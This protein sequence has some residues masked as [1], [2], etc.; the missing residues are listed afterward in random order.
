MG[1]GIVSK[2]PAKFSKNVLMSDSIYI[3]NIAINQKSKIASNKTLNETKLPFLAEKKLKELM[4][5]KIYDDLKKGG[6][7][8]NILDLSSFSNEKENIEIL[9]QI[10]K[11]TKELADKLSL[12]GMINNNIAKHYVEI[13]RKIEKS[14]KLKLELLDLSS[15]RNKKRLVFILKLMV[16]LLNIARY[17]KDDGSFSEEKWWKPKKDEAFIHTLARRVMNKCEAIVENY[18]NVEFFYLKIFI[19]SRAK[20]KKVA[21]QILQVSMVF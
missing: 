6:K 10:N 21:L 13:T 5:Y 12:A 4:D 18:E 20:K 2:S 15:E 19:N 17:F 9:L 1:N 16:H 3:K 7:L 11:K 14:F 8:S